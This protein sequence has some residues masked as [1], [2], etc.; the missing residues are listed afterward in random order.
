MKKKILGSIMCICLSLSLCICTVSEVNAANGIAFARTA[1]W[2]IIK[3]GANTFY[4]RK[5]TIEKGANYT[6]SSTGTIEFNQGNYGAS[7][8]VA[9]NL[10]K[11]RMVVDAFAKTNFL[12]WTDKI[13]ILLTTPDGKKDVINKSVE[14]TQLAS[15]NSKSPYGTYQLRFV[16]NTAK[17]WDCWYTV[18][19]FDISTKSAVRKAKSENGKTISYI[20][21]NDEDKRVY[22]ISS[23]TH[24]NS[25][26]ISRS[27]SEDKLSISELSS[28]FYDEEYNTYVNDLKDYTVGDVVYFKDK[29]Q[30]IFY[31]ESENSTTFEFD[32][33]GYTIEWKF[34][35]NLVNDYHVNDFLELKFN[36]VQDYSSDGYVFENIDY[37]RD[38]WNLN[39]SY[40]NINDYLV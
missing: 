40:P 5:P 24:N 9:I 19:D 23:K 18:A 8:K 21:S 29:I 34:N 31:N 10:H 33:N 35:G 3:K 7:T 15:Y 13:S 37:I 30:N 16:K 17:N 27:V 1:L 25:K 26:P 12:N 28:Q 22:T 38:G 32:D 6:T 4:E 36:V 11:S 20:V 2:Y 39:E 14:H